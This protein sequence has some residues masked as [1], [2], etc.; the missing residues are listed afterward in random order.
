M[1]I[2]GQKKRKL[3]SHW[4]ILTPPTHLPLHVRQMERRRR[5]RR[6]ASATVAA[7]ALLCPLL[8]FL[9][10]LLLLLLLL[11]PQHRAQSGSI[12]AMFVEWPTDR[13]VRGWFI[14]PRVTHAS[15]LLFLLLLPGLLR[16][17]QPFVFHSWHL[18]AHQYIQPHHY[19]K[20]L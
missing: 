1:M 9:L 14:D 15:L 4:T 17:I 20:T 19:R 8:L 13:P 18:S 6:E 11:H 7:A 3:K 12:G 2:I 5:R 10:L 16:L